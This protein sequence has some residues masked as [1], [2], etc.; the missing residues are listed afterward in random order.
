[1]RI[2]ILIFVTFLVVSCQNQ[3]SKQNDPADIARAEVLA[4]DF[5]KNLAKHNI[6][7]IVTK[8]DSIDPEVAKKMILQKEQ[9]NGE[10]I[11]VDFKS[12]SSTRTVTNGKNEKVEFIIEAEVSYANG[13]TSEELN[14]VKYNS[15]QELLKF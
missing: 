9:L 1:M 8:T 12:F 15:S 13:K 3:I 14:F 5:Y 11:K 6:D 4:S 10:I 7:A 2:V